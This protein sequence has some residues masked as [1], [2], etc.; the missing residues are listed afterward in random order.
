MKKTF[1]FY[2]IHL[3]TFLQVNGNFNNILLSDSWSSEVMDLIKI[4]SA[5]FACGRYEDCDK[6]FLLKLNKYGEVEWKQD[7]VGPNYSSATNLTKLSDGNILCSGHDLYTDDL[8]GFESIFVQKIS[9][10]GNI[11]FSTQI[12]HDQNTL[13]Q[14]IPL[15][16]ATPNKIFLGIDDQIVLINSNGDSIESYSHNHGNVYHLIKTK[17]SEILVST[18]TGLQLLDTLGQQVLFKNFS[19]KVE[20]AYPWNDSCYLIYTN[21]Q[22][23]EL[24]SA[25]NVK[26][27]VPLNNEFSKVADI[28]LNNGKCYLSGLNNIDGVNRV[29]I[30]DFNLQNVNDV[31]LQDSNLI[32]G[33]ISLYDSS[34]VISGQDQYAP[35]GHAFIKKY[36][37]NGQIIYD[38]LD[39][40]IS[41]FRIVDY[42][43]NQFS[44]IGNN[45]TLF[46]Y[47]VFLSY[48]V[49]NNTSD[50]ISSYAIHSDGY[51][52]VNC[53]V[54]SVRELERVALQGNSQKSFSVKLSNITSGSN[55]FCFYAIGPNGNV[56]KDRSNNKFCFENLIV[57]IEEKFRSNIS[58]YPNPFSDKLFLTL[59][60][61][62][63]SQLKL[64]DLK[65]NLVFSDI[66]QNT[67]NYHADLQEL[68]IGVYVL[69][70]NIEGKKITE[71]IIKIK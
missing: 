57:N 29:K 12:A 39:I 18:E 54:E 15:L 5:W 49:F 23:L 11:L 10:S 4:D 13:I 68:T 66:I 67:T 46:Y 36:N 38:S 59:N 31:V 60:N 58:I 44:T 30:F 71:K 37:E 50:Y 17:S 64:Y 48:D 43:V 19:N 56:D 52:M 33:K 41:N 8:P 63:I 34:L 9:T 47:D 69:E 16:E 65:G 53:H 21:L 61:V 24:D 55:E 32:V 35:G 28:K 1:I 14:K 70:I 26:N 62:E 25:F 7:L 6:A 40:S 27:S 20:Y 42:D 3:F 2:L 22:L 51:N 45:D